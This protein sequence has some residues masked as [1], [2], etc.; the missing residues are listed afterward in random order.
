MEEIILFCGKVLGILSEQPPSE[1]LM[2]LMA[3]KQ[4]FNDAQE[5]SCTEGWFLDHIDEFCFDDEALEFINHQG[6]LARFYLV[7]LANAKD[8][9]DLQKRLISVYYNE[10]MHAYVVR[11]NRL[12]CDYL[13]L[14]DLTRE[15]QDM[16][17]MDEAHK[18]VR[19]IYKLFCQ[20]R[21]LRLATG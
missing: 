14:W 5:K 2:H 7:H 1:R 16:I 17:Y 19:R 4:H 20:R 6:W 12:L 21:T 15:A 9:L 13:L 3:M 10:M 8:N 18:E 11:Y